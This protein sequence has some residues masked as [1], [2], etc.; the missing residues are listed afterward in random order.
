MHLRGAPSAI[1]MAVIPKDQISLCNK[2]KVPGHYSFSTP[3]PQGRAHLPPRCCSHPVVI[4]G[5]RVLIT[6]NNFRRHPV[7][8]A[9]E[10]VSTPNSP[11]Q[12]ST[13]A[14][15]NW[16]CTE[17]IRWRGSMWGGQRRHILSQHKGQQ[18]FKLPTYQVW[19]LRS[20]WAAHSG[21]WCLCGWLYGH[22][23]EKGPAH[24]QRT[25]E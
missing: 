22:G 15:V 20:L 8:C 1:S 14:E 3:P 21:P 25:P 10:G 24:R 7:R 11:V 23:G 6:G 4:G 2:Q 9:N 13:H 19:P 18:T 5:V 16:M 17:Q 12:L